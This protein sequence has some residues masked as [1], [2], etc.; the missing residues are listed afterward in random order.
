MKNSFDAIKHLMDANGVSKKDLAVIAGV[1][2]SA[3]TKWASGGAIR[4]KYL[5]KIAQ[6]FRM[7]TSLLLAESVVS[8]DS[9]KVKQSKVS[10]WQERAL[11]AERKLESIKSVVRSL[12]DCVSKLE[13]I[14]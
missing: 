10:Y 5:H 6:H 8:P 13:G 2:P 11:L 14:V 12:T 4:L 9:N 7:D 3:V 1:G